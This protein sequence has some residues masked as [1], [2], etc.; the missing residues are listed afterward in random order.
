M[1]SIE[2]SIYENQ[3]EIIEVIRKGIQIPSVK[4]EAQENAPYGK[5]VK[6][7]LEFSLE[8]GESW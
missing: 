6:R 4:G 3:N 1:K 8:L 5:N 2:N 7:I